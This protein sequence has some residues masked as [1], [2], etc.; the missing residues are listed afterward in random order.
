[1]KEVSDELV[2]AIRLI[3]GNYEA[4]TKALV[5]EIIALDYPTNDFTAMETLICS[6]IHMFMNRFYTTNQRF[7]ELVMYIT[8]EQWLKSVKARKKVTSNTVSL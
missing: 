6:H 2:A 4:Q 7:F 5:S 1:M 8:Y 3:I